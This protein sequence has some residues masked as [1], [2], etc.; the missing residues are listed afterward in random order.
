LGLVFFKYLSDS[1]LVKVYDLLN[2]EQPKN[3]FDAQEAYEDAM[4][5]SDK[6]DLFLRLNIAKG[7]IE[8]IKIWSQ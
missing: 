2:D 3:L 8:I 4:N 5:S 7:K 1:Y 6:E